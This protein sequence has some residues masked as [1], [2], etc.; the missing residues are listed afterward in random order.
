MYQETS[1]LRKSFSGFVHSL[2]IIYPAEEAKSIAYLVFEKLLGYT[3]TQIHLRGDELLPRAFFEQLNLMEHELKNHKPVQYVLGEASFRNLTLQ[4]SPAVLIPR[5]ET[6]ELV[7]WI[8]HTIKE[9]KMIA[10]AILDIGTGSGCI[11]ISLKKESPKSAI[12]ALDISEDALRITRRNAKNNEVEL[13]IIQGDILHKKWIQEQ[14]PFWE[15]FDIMVSNPPYVT[16]SE[17]AMMRKNVLEHEPSLALFVSDIDPLIF[18]RNIIEIVQAIKGKKRFLFFEINETFAG[19]M[20][21]L[22]EEMNFKNIELRKDFFG[23][24]RMIKAESSEH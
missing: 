21:S 16:F 20:K 13:D 5:P 8:L 22:L 17:K 3:K 2:S 23:K 18:Y 1:T 10:P 14:I 19:A 4:V 15:K 7:E 11:A 24:Y 6:E 12:A 9:E